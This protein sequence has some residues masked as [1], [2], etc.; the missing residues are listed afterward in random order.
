MFQCHFQTPVVTSIDWPAASVTIA[1][2]TSDR[3]PGR[4]LKR[5]VLPLAISVLTASLP[6]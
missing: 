1:F 3:R 5:F 4:P 6:P 2:F